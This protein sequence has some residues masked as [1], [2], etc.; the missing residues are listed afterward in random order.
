MDAFAS[1]RQAFSSYTRNI[2]GYFVSSLV[3]WI[4]MLVA[5]GLPFG[6][7]ALSMLVLGAFAAGDIPS[8]LFSNIVLG[9]IFM[10]WMLFI[11]L[12]HAF[13]AGAGIGAFF[14]SCHSLAQGR[15]PSML[16]SIEY[17]I[18]NG[19][20]FLAL[21]VIFYALIA[22][23][24]LPALI[25]YLFLNNTLVSVAL[26]LLGIGALALAKFLLMFA[27]PSAAIDNTTPLGAIVRSMRL[28]LSRLPQCII[29]AISICIMGAI[30][31]PI[32]IINTFVFAP[33]AFTSLALFYKNAR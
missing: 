2:A 7:F 15:A 6:M 22:V 23:F 26:L 4:W 11:F 8:L 31:G 17:G 20:R 12:L 13:F 28:V 33:I 29:F 32:P 1:I 16:A 18:K 27:F 3:Y 25:S 21:T 5:L 14:N 30:L 9:A 24:L 19:G 10:L